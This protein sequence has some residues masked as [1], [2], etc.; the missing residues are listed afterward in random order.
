MAHTRWHRT[1][2]ELVSIYKR[3]HREAWFVSV[4]TSSG[5]VKRSTGTTHRSTARAMDRMLESLGPNGQRAWDLLDRIA[6]NTLTVGQLY[7]AWQM[8]DLQGLRER[9]QGDVDLEPH[10]TNW[11]A[12]LADYVKP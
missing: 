3:F 6:A 1:D 4:P 10:I 12:R 9:L 8:N 2:S 7:D 11:S 5:R